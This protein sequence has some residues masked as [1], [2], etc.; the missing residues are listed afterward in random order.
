MLRINKKLEYGII[1][2]LYLSGKQDRTASVREM[3]TQSRIPEALLS[4]VMQAFKSEEIVSA[5][6]GNQG[7]YR[8][9]RELGDINLLQLLEVLEGPIRV[10]ECLE[11]GNDTC[12]C[13]AACTIVTPMETLNQRIIELFQTTSIEALVSKK[14]AV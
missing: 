1:A 5:V 7:G 3:A 11:A 9:S 14:V 4:K 2:L 8:L 13:R 12:R 10:A 6:Y